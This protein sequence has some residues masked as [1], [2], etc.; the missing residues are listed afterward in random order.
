[1]INY[2]SI[3]FKCGLE[4]HYQLS[5]RKLFCHCPNL[6]NDPNPCVFETTRK[7]RAFEGELGKRDIAAEYE[8]S[9]EKTFIYRGAETSSCLVD[10]DEAPPYPI[11]KDAIKAAI[12]VAKL[13]HMDIVDEIIIMR[14]LVIDGSNP[15]GYQRTALI[16]RNGYIE[17]SKGKINLQT[18]YLEEDASK[19]IKTE[20]NKITYDLSRLGIPLLEIGTSPDLKDP[21]HVKETASTI[22]M[23]VKSTG[24]ARRGI[25]SVRQDVNISIKNHN[26]IELKGFQDLR[27]IPKVIDVEIQRQ[28]RNKK[29]SPHVR[30]V[31]PN[32][33]SS[34]LRPLPGSARMYPDTDLTQ[35]QITP[36]F[37]KEI[38]IPELLTDRALNFEKKYNISSLYAREILKQNIPFDYYAEKYKVEPKFIATL[39]LETP[40][41]L[42]SRFN[43]K[44]EPKK[45]HFEFMIIS[46]T[47]SICISFATCMAAFIASLLI[48]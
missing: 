4:V 14:K 17:T 15:S 39:L 40:K 38:D 24:L 25:G 5:T 27:S 32:F 22:G 16:G 47:M 8:A 45:E 9:K 48:G 21:E 1:M 41:E 43:T 46:S 6:I 18:L 2:K 20:K 42:K 7:L 28:Q 37:I 29:E 30:K 31:E 33:T 36:S 13:M 12:Q 44:N 19:K 34:Y 23:I 10:F 11:N 3:G 26:R 35:F